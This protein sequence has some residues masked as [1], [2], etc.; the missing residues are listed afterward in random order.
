MALRDQASL[1]KKTVIC[2]KCK[3][4]VEAFDIEFYEEDGLFHRFICHDCAFDQR[5]ILSEFARRLKEQN[6]HE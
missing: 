6:T 3:Q 5:C 1:S 2:S 4:W